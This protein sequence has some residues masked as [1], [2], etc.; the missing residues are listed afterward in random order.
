MEYGAAKSAHKKETGVHFHNSKAGSFRIPSSAIAK[1]KMR[2]PRVAFTHNKPW[3]FLGLLP[4]PSFSSGWWKLCVLHIICASIFHQHFLNLQSCRAR[5]FWASFLFWRLHARE[6]RLK[7]G[8]HSQRVVSISCARKWSASYRDKLAPWATLRCI[9]KAHAISIRRKSGGRRSLCICAGKFTQ[10]FTPV[11]KISFW[12]GNR[13]K[14]GVIIY[15]DAL[16]NQVCHNN[17]RCVHQ[18]QINMVA[19]LRTKITEFLFLN[20]EIQ[21]MIRWFKYEEPNRVNFNAM[22]FKWKLFWSFL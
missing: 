1:W 8:K 5:A 13:R 16:K 19:S 6:I 20:L 7:G 14:Q 11:S 21:V 3:R 4:E 2:R 12:A 9:F 10:Y 15:Y 17:G 18:N 22:V